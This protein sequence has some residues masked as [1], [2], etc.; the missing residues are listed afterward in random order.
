MPEEYKLAYRGGTGEIVEK[1]SRFYR[2][3]NAGVK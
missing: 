3:C 2:R 1:K